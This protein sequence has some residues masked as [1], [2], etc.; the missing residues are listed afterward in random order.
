VKTHKKRAKCSGVRDPAAYKKSTELATPASIDQDYNFITKVQQD[1]DRAEDDTA[2]RGIT[3]V[4]AKAGR[5]GHPT[6]SKLEIEY[7]ACGVTVVKA[8]AGLTR[9]K[10]NKTHWHNRH[11]C[12]TWT[13]EWILQDGRRVLANVQGGKDVFDA[14]TNAV[15]RKGLPRKRKLEEDAQ[16]EG[17]RSPG[18]ISK[19]TDAV[20]HDTNKEDLANGLP[21]PQDDNGENTDEEKDTKGTNANDSPKRESQQTTV[22]DHIAPD[23]HFYL[24]RP[25]TSSKW[26][27][28]IPVLPSSSISDMLRGR[29]ILEFPTIHARH[30]APTQLQ[31]PLITEKNY[32]GQH[33]IDVA[34]KLPVYVQDD[35]RSSIELV[36]DHIDERKVM[37]VLQKDLVGQNPVGSTPISQGQTDALPINHH[38]Q[39]RPVH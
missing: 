13:V 16:G 20:A 35:P 4:A 22:D 38:K 28:L 27:C 34:L 29:T 8:P 1:I 32:E 33:G 26:T 14:F 11:K 12:I 15:G 6:K 31:P 18:Q 3:L 21:K 23:M 7:E 19:R 39:P 2:E 17:G 37:E 5:Q 24:H 36:P 10:Q 30:D 25:R 9:S